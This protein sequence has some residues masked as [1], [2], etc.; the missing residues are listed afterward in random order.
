MSHKGNEAAAAPSQKVKPSSS[1]RDAK[2]RKK[3]PVKVM[4]IADPE[5][6][7]PVAP[8]APAV[9][10]ATL[11][12]SKAALPRVTNIADPAAAPPASGPSTAAAAPPA[13]TREFTEAPKQSTL[14]QPV[15][16]DAQDFAAMLQQL[17]Q[18]VRKPVQAPRVQLNAE[19]E[20][21]DVSGKKVELNDN[22]ATV[23]V[24]QNKPLVKPRKIRIEKAPDIRLNPYYDASLG[25]I[26]A[27]RRRPAALQFY[28]SGALVERAEKVRKMAEARDSF[29]QAFATSSTTDA[30]GPEPECQAEPENVDD[31]D[32]LEEPPIMEWWDDR[33]LAKDAPQREYSVIDDTLSCINQNLISHYV[34]HPQ[35]VAGPNTPKPA[36]PI[37]LLLTKQERKKMRTQGRVA[38]EKEKQEQIRLGLMEPP[39]PKVKINN[40][41][42]VLGTEAASDPTA[43]EKFVRDE[44]EARRSAHDARN[45]ERKLT[46]EQR[47]AKKIQKLEKEADMDPITTIF[48]I[49]DLSNKGKRLKVDMNANQLKLT[50]CAII[51]GPINMVVIEGGRKPTRK[52]VHLMTSRVHWGEDDILQ[53][54]GKSSGVSNWC[55]LVWQGCSATKQFTTFK[56]QQFASAE[57]AKKFMTDKGCIYLWDMVE[58]FKRG[59]AAAVLDDD[60]EDEA[61]L[62]AVKVERSG[63]VEKS[64]KVEKVE[65]GGVT[66]K[67]EEGDDNVEPALV[68]V[69]K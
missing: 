61:D 33:L 55:S 18:T 13:S 53:E 32:D 5:A 40:L 39:K 20:I 25:T 21:V 3:I 46:P 38:R 41:M 28:E 24:N 1:S 50:G 43:M 60:S 15:L 8:A 52:F 4:D 2:K 14:P 47:R 64:E 65:G 12:K 48:K 36:G 22:L 49:G 10:A 69:E 23:K 7:M 34:E 27:K 59:D 35:P 29:A 45:Q 44:M 57:K 68:K 56:L 63:K 66:V 11:K 62:P 17:T 54:D 67:L 51:S 42:R 31:D 58:K 16:T 37:A 6:D 19:G 9:P 26:P 30:G